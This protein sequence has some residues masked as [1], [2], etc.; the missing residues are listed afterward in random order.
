M[1]RYE[2]LPETLLSAVSKV[3]SDC[4]RRAGNTEYEGA[5]KFSTSS[6]G[7]CH[8]MDVETQSPINSPGNNIDDLIPTE[9]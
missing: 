1:W 5:S 7:S 3:Y 6:S 4:T 2:I 8:N 9:N